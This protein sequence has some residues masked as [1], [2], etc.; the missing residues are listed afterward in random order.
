M[1]ATS[2]LDAVSP[3][4][5]VM[6]RGIAFRSRC[7]PI[8][9]FAA[10]GRLFRRWRIHARLD[11]IAAAFCDLNLNPFLFQIESGR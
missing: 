3:W 10:F 8:D 6:H 7:Q 2:R 5:T 11:A 4:R 9:P 1:M